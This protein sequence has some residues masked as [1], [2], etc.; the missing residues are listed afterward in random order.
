MG[1]GQQKLPEGAMG[2]LLQSFLGRGREIERQS[3]EKFV[4]IV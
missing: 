4:F 3:L 1:E 2:G